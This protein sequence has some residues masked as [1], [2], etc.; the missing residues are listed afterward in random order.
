MREGGA[1]VREGGEEDTEE[2]S[3]SSSDGDNAGKED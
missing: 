2:V 3:R 1:E